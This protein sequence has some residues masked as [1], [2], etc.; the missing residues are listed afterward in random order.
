MGLDCQQYQFKSAPDRLGIGELCARDCL[1]VVLQAD[2]LQPVRTQC[3]QART[4]I[5]KRHIVALM[6]QRAAEQSADCARAQDTN[7]RRRI[8]CVNSRIPLLHIGHG[9]LEALDHLP[10]AVCQ[11]LWK[12]SHE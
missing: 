7:P 10:R 9:I 2:K 5:D 4:M 11:P 1:N 8:H 12:P 3:S 6:R